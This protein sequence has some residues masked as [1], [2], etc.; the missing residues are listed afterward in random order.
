[1]IFDRHVAWYIIERRVTAFHRPVRS[2]RPGWAE[3]ELHKVEVIRTVSWL[4][5]ERQ[6]DDDGE[7]QV[8][9]GFI[10]ILD[11]EQRQLA[12]L[13]ED[14]AAAA[15]WSSLDRMMEWWR[16]KHGTGPLD[17]EARCWTVTFELSDEHI[18]RLLHQDSSHGYTHDPRLAL[19]D[20]PEAVD[21]EAQAKITENAGTIFSV[22]HADEQ[23]KRDARSL[24][25]RLKEE[26]ARAQREGVDIDENVQRIRAELDEIRRKRQDAA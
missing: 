19:A 9:L 23:R 25:A 21:A 6:S 1:M 4:D 2:P 17:P 22:T 13:T 15:G 10:R 24:S 5:K 8:L 3:G 11:V 12:D 18:P 20:E 16:E 14:D 7:R 26:T